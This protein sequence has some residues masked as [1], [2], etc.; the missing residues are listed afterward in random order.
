M[1]H[2]FH[3][4]MLCVSNHALF[5]SMVEKLRENLEDSLRGDHFDP[6]AT[7]KGNLFGNKST[8]IQLLGKKNPTSGLHKELRWQ[9]QQL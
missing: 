9:G 4:I 7:A 2:I 6:E 8:T 5:I 1:A 3:P